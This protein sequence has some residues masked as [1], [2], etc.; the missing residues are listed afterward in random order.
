M[1]FKYLPVFLHTKHL[2]RKSEKCKMFRNIFILIHRIPQQ[3]LCL[4]V[5]KRGIILGNNKTHNAVSATMFVC[6]LRSTLSVF[7]FFLQ[8][9][10]S[11]LGL[12]EFSESKAHDKLRRYRYFLCKEWAKILQGNFDA[13][14]ALDYVQNTRLYSCMLRV[15]NREAN[16]R[17]KNAL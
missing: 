11:R 3:L 15:V 12:F 17:G 9:V 1:N 5:R 4:P 8:L 6:F 7:F 16:P 14:V 2:L 13:S 10:P